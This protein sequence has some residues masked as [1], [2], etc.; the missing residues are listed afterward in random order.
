MQ[1][2]QQQTATAVWK[3]RRRLDIRTAREE[4]SPAAIDTFVQNLI[5]SQATVVGLM[6]DRTLVDNLQE[7]RPLAFRF[8]LNGRI[9]KLELLLLAK[10]SA[11]RTMG[12]AHVHLPELAKGGQRAK[13]TPARR[14]VADPRPF[15]PSIGKPL[16]LVLRNG[17]VL[18]LPL[19]TVG[20]FDLLLGWSGNEVLVHLHAITFWE[21]A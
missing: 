7:T 8:R 4:V 5:N 11:W 19:L 16:V 9:E 3:E 1:D 14:P 6:R 10:H 12:M 13:A 17:M 15:L 21:T 2:F 18:H 20:P